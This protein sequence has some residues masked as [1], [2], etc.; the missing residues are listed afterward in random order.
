LHHIGFIN[1]KQAGFSI[2]I[3]P[4]K[5]REHPVT[6]AFGRFVETLKSMDVRVSK[7]FGVHQP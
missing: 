4:V 1:K 2:Y 7:G 5:G 6:G 3:E